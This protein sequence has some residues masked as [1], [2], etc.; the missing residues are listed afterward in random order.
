MVVNG[1]GA[2]A[3]AVTVVVMAVVKFMAGAWVVVLLVPSLILLMLAVRRH[4]RRNRTRNFGA[5]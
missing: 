1:L 2:S 5:R 3:T 4:Y